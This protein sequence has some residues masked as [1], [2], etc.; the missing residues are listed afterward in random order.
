ML[1]YLRRRVP[2]IRFCTVILFISGLETFRLETVV[3]RYG[4][5]SQ[6]NGNPSNS[7]RDVCSIGSQLWRRRVFDFSLKDEERNSREAKDHLE[8]QVKS[9]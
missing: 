2:P 1:Q 7:R 5:G 4:G 9:L 6:G 3:M 8:I